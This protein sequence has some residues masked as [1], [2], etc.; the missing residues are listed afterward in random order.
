MDQTNLIYLLSIPGRLAPE[1]MEAARLVHNSTAGAPANVAA[2]KSLG[3][4]SH[5]VY[6]PLGQVDGDASNF[7]I[8]DLW[9]N[10][11]GLNTFFANKQVQEQAGQIFSQRDPVV[12]V[13]AEGFH[14]YHIPAP[15]GKNERYVGI[16]RGTV[17]SRADGQ[18]RHNDL[19]N[20]AIN[21]A[22]AAGSLSH[23]A[24]FRQSP[25]GA[26]ESL[27]FFAVDVWMS[28]SGMGQYYDDPEFL[29]GFQEMFAAPPSASVWVHPA[30][31]WVEW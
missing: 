4:L 13:P 26:P 31:E 1:T 21:K 5:M 27:E 30:G 12:W 16:V 17:R 15:F 23:E 18:K 3:D 29:S 24:Y 10:M 11:D 7:L 9:N 6:K 22:R 2:A 20:K 28:D 8:L 19:V 25:P 14:G